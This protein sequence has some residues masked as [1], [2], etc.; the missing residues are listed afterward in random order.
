MLFV[1]ARAHFG[2]LLHVNPPF[3]TILYGGQ[4]INY[5]NLSGSCSSSTKFSGMHLT[6]HLRL[7]YWAQ[8]L[9]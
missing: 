6:R 8:L 9:L 1:L 3:H 5:K 7:R 2:Q 4:Q